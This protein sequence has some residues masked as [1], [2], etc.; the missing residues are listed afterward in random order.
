[1]SPTSVLDIGCD[2]GLAT[3]FYALLYPDAKIIGI[4][5][6]EKA[7]EC[8][9]ELATQLELKNINFL[10]VDFS[11]IHQHFPSQSFDL[12]VSL[13]TLHEI[14]QPTT[15]PREWTLEAGIKK[16]YQEVD[17]E[18]V[19]KNIESLLTDHGVLL[20]TDR[21]SNVD[22]IAMW[23]IKLEKSGLFV[24]WEKSKDITF[25]QTGELQT[26]P[27]LYLSKTP[28]QTELLEG[29]L[30]LRMNPKTHTPSFG[31]HLNDTE[32]EMMFQQIEPKELI[33]GVQF[34]YLNGSG[35]MRVELWKSGA[36]L[37]EYKYSNVG[38]RS[39]RILPKGR[40]GS[41]KKEFKQL[42]NE[43]EYFTESAIYNSVEERDKLGYL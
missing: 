7:I 20:T 36:K 31:I 27:A 25:D 42:E 29:V 3:C 37:I 17:P 13:S 18:T 33:T 23:A 39:I 26:V 32:A 10:A 22:Y 41:L 43:Y 9:K 28:L 2:N 24:D 12:I 6:N 34:M 40:L 5:S 38:Y 35:T 21:L 4:D 1:L 30:G 16:A 14:V 11:D 8:A 15:L 19:F